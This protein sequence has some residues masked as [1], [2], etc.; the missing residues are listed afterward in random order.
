MERRK[1]AVLFLFL[2]KLL[3]FSQVIK[4]VLRN[5]FYELRQETTIDKRKQASGGSCQSLKGQG[6]I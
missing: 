2:K 3:F 6:I 5:T 1:Q 4:I